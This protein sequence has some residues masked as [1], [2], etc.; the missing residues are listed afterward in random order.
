MSKA[1]T[2]AKK[3]VSK[4]A[5][6]KSSTTTKRPAPEVLPRPKRRKPIHL[7]AEHAK[8][9]ARYERAEKEKTSHDT[10]SR[11]VAKALQEDL[12][13]SK[14]G[15]IRANAFWSLTYYYRVDQRENTGRDPDYTIRL[16]LMDKA[17]EALREDMDDEDFD[18][19][20]M[21]FR[22]RMDIYVKRRGEIEEKAREVQAKR[23]ER[24][25]EKAAEKKKKEEEKEKELRK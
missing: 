3:S 8:D 18:F 16:G 5:V 22:E 24:K 6:T 7:Y 21:D 10:S 13:K 20:E 9:Y 15:Y 11:K 1:S 19:I 12:A 2:P 25:R 14:F 17:I 23:E 4:K